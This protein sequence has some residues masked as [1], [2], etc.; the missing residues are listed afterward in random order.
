MKTREEY[1]KEMDEVVQQLNALE[2]QRQELT[3]R[4]IELQG[5]LKALQEDDLSKIKQ[6]EPEETKSE[7]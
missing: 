7:S 3:N 6:P 2:R 4:G 5:V 1:K